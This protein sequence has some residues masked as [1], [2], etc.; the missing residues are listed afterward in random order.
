MG[1]ESPFINTQD[2]IIDEIEK[3]IV[4]SIHVSTKFSFDGSQSRFALNY[5][6]LGVLSFINNTNLAI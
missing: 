6:D 4:I 5:F 1:M 3:K 2:V